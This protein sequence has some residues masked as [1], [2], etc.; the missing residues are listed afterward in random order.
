[1]P[2]LHVVVARYNEDISWLEDLRK[3]RPETKFTVYNKHSGDNLLPNVGRESHTYVHHIM[4][5]YESP[6]DHYLFLQGDPFEHE[7]PNGI[8]QKIVENYDSHYFR[9]DYC[10]LNK[11]LIDDLNGFPY[12]WRSGGLPLGCLYEKVFGAGTSP[13]VFEFSPGACFLV[14]GSMFKNLSHESWSILHDHL[15][16]TQKPIE[17]YCVE[18]LWK[19]LFCKVSDKTFRDVPYHLYKN[20]QEYLNLAI[21][22]DKVSLL[23]IGLGRER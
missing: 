12:S 4:K 10:S 11:E 3:I 9:Y 8:I 14:S 19:S 22:D 2:V 23:N 15:C 21:K 20:Y 17:S 1:M 6:D 16:K 18:R 7:N 5:D 13:Q